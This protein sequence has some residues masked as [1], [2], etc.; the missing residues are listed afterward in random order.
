MKY[1]FIKKELDEH[2]ERL[3]Q[4]ARTHLED[5]LLKR[6]GKMKHDGVAVDTDE[7]MIPKV[8][9]LAV[10]YLI[11][12]EPLDEDL[13]GYVTRAFAHVLQSMSLKDLQLQIVD[14][15]DSFL[16]E[17]NSKMINCS[18]AHLSNP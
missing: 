5:N 17:I 12:I 15:F 14:S 1:L 7:D 18:C 6:D 3:Y 13:P 16:E 10:L 2:P 4:C 8:E 11:L 9:C